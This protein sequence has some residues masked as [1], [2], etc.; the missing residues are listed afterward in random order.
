MDGNRLQRIPL[1]RDL[2]RLG[3]L[4]V[5]LILSLATAGRGLALSR[6]KRFG[7]T[8]PRSQPA[9]SKAAP[10]TATVAEVRIDRIQSASS[11]R[12]FSRRSRRTTHGCL[13]G[14]AIRQRAGET[15]QGG[16]SGNPHRDHPQRRRHRA[17]LR[18]ARRDQGGPLADEVPVPVRGTAE[19]TARTT[20]RR[21][22]TST[23]RSR[24]TRRAP[25]SS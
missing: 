12:P 5:R 2:L 18:D 8:G 23:P 1:H 16:H 25:P 3:D 17:A 24:R 6:H 9:V 22:A 11:Y 10:G 21:S 14:R 20:A 13:L 4:R 7:A 15:K 19:S